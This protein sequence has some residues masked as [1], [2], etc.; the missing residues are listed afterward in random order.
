MTDT[1]APVHVSTPRD[2]RRVSRAFAAILM[3]L[4]PLSVAILR[5][6]LPYNTTDSPQG[7]V[8]KIAAHPAAERLVLW[9]TVLA[10]VTLVPGALAAIKLARRRAP[11]LS[12][13]SALLLIPAYLSMYGVVLVDEVGI[14][15]ASHNGA[16]VITVGQIAKLVNDLPTT[17]V[18]S[19]LFVAGH[20]TGSILLALAL[21]RSRYVG[22]LGCWILGI[23]QPVHVVAAIIGNH[24]LD[25]IG[26]LLT[27]L[28]MAFAARA[29]TLLPDN[30]WDL[31]PA[32]PAHD[33]A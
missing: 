4:G 6:V 18:L 12:A 11:I 22:R 13:M 31:P 19:A 24:P 25:L 26:W 8:D 23:S 33:V 9:L 1:L 10:T 14:T 17:T 2:L 30:E 16:G 3:P 21:R 29:I 20:V 28:G 27:A 15:A 5:F 7:A 32:S